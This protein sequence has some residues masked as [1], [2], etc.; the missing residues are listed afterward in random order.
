MAKL[1]RH[2]F[3]KSQKNGKRK[4]LSA[5]SYLTAPTK[6]WWL[7]VV[8]EFELEQHHLKLLTAACESWDRTQQARKRLAK[9]GLTYQDRFGQPR[10]RPEVQIE[11]DH[12]IAFA[13]LL[14]ELDLDVDPPGPP[15]RP[16]GRR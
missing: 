10:T 13:R 9:H 5:P 11:R 15:G 3:S 4:K 8:S 12:R 6:D 14:R 2:K 7:W 16:P 1:I